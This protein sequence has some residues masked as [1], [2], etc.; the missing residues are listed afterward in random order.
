NARAQAAAAEATRDNSDATDELAEAYNELLNDLGAGSS[1]FVS[2][3]GA[4]DATQAKTQEWAQGQA[5]ATATVEDTWEDFYD[6]HSVKLDEYLAELQSMVDA[7]TNWQ[8]NITALVGRVSTDTLREL[9][10]L[11][12]EAAPLVQSLVDGTDEQLAEF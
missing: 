6:G 1:E 3:T 10:R 5:D 9:E 11:G 4:L 12:T 7:Q 8:S 2:I